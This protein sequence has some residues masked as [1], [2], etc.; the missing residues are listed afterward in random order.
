MKKR[1]LIYKGSRKQ[2]AIMLNTLYKSPRIK[3]KENETVT[4]GE[5]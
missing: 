4:H 2:R 5:E 1:K 3:F